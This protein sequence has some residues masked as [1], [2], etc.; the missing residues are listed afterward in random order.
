MS[1][2]RQVALLPAG[3]QPWNTD[4]CDASGE[5][6]AYSATLAIYIYQLDRKFNEFKLHSVMSEHKKTITAISWNPRNPDI[7]ASTGADNQV[8]VWNIPQQR[9]LDKITTKT[10]PN[11]VGW[12]LHE[13]DC[14]SFVCGRGPLCMWNYGT[15]GG[16]TFH[17][18]AQNF[19]SDICQ[20]RWHHKKLGKLAFGHT[21]GSLS[22][23]NP[24]QKSQKHVL[25][26]ETLEGTD[27][28]DPVSDLDWD[29][30]SSEYLL[31]SNTH[32]GVRLIDTDS[33]SIIMCFQL[34]SAAAQVHSIAWI[35]SAP[36]M[37]LTG[38]SH[39]GVM[40]M[41]N[42]SKASPIENIKLK[43]MGFHA[44]HVFSTAPQPGNNNN[45]MATSQGVS[46]TSYT[47]AP[48]MSQTN[49]FALPPAHAV[50]TF[51]DGGVGLYDLG[52]RKWNFLRSEGHVETIFD[53][54]FKPD[55]PDLLAT[56]SFDGTVKVWDITDMTAVETS[57]GN[58][59]V[60]YSIT[61]APGD[62]NCIAGSTSRQGAFIWDIDKGKIVKRFTEHGKHSV[63]SVA[64]CPK[65]S[66][67]IATCG[68]DGHCI[69]RQVDGKI[70]QK[71]KHPAAVFGCDWS[72]HNKDMIATGCEDK[73]VRV[74]YLPTN[75]EQPLKIFAGHSAK[76][77]HVRWSPLREGI[78]CSGSDD[79]GI[80]IW[81]YTQDACINFLEGHKAPVR[82]LLW[83]SEIP[84]LLISG[85]WDYTIRIWDIRDGACIDTVLDHG[86]DVYGLACHPSRPFILASCSRDSTLR[87][88]SLT[89]LV[90]PLQM[91]ILAKR[92]WSE[93]I[94]TAENATSGVSPLLTGKVSKD[95]RAQLEKLQEPELYCKT[96]KLFSNFFTHPGG[97]QNLWELVGVINGKADCYLSSNYSKGIMHSKHLTKY[98]ASA[99]QELEMVK[100]SRSSG[101]G[102]PKKEDQLR[103]AA[104]MHIRLGNIQRYCELMV[105]LGEWERAMAVA[106][107]VS[108]D[109]WKSLADRHAD[110]LM[111]QENELA[112]PFCIATGSAKKC[113]DFLTSQGHLQEAMLVAEATIE[114]SINP[115]SKPSKKPPLNCNGGETPNEDDLSM[116]H[117]T[118]DTL[119]DW[120]FRNGSPI[121][122]ACCHLS[123]DHCQKA[124][125]K[126]IRG[127]EL[128][129]AVS[130]GR[131]LKNQDVGALTNVATE[132][133]VR[134]CENIGKWELA[135][136]LLKDT[137]DSERHLVR[138]CASCAASQ[139]EIDDL[140]SKAGLPSMQKCLK[141][142]E[143][144]LS[145][146]SPEDCVKYY[147]LSTQPEK[148]LDVGLEHIKGQMQRSVWKVADVYPVLQLLGYI[149]TEKLQQQKCAKYCGE[150]LALSAY[151]GALVAIGRGYDTIV[152]PLFEHTRYLL[153]SRQPNIPLSE[154]QLDLDL[155]AWRS[156]G[157]QD[158]DTLGT[159][160]GSAC[161]HYKV[162]RERIGVEPYPVERG[163]DVAA[164]SAMPSHSDV[165]MSVLNGRR[166]QGLAFFLEDG[167]S[168]VSISDA[169]M[170]SK[171]NP[172]SPLAT[173]AR[174]NP[175]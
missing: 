24:G 153:K 10:T 30:L 136:D 168:A 60:I 88:W 37:F 155:A 122:A 146:S 94:G 150:L 89:P 13:R 85:S 164:G 63:Y 98:K 120:Y 84:Y 126:L 20:F 169:I 138:L 69:I 90:E 51:L 117:N 46:S 123:V 92:P 113:V 140:H 58:E 143:T 125:S 158:R 109:Y 102:A 18:E 68:A 48:T 165:H 12:C 104:N 172:F 131:V 32:F 132:Y 142:A 14:V 106:P 163:V 56:A 11:S 124:M 35:P 3:C 38:D 100:M 6:F 118:A 167:R 115:P 139:S 55:N 133:L 161:E 65:D 151:V 72:P 130:I 145:Q 23:F 101:I 74:Y 9:A 25:R 40:R 95:L 137:D 129:L 107:G 147:I 108:L 34:P 99:A 91:N 31:V 47:I 116:L 160:Y 36:G 93:I 67:R 82:G 4:V 28:E 81:D 50:C 170:W 166:I 97:S 33:L 128:E 112:I 22:L 173:G 156:Q 5:R 27:E 76:V 73:T 78:L 61:W 127:N 103:E 144:L 71:Y 59:G 26:P 157:E 121:L 7:L 119:A 79:G 80:R 159:T 17:K 39:V 66:R 114:G 62:I 105:D 43:K 162:L 70:L 86:A 16:L 141:K 175:F 41:W 52:K 8:I 49:R 42:V 57:P 154:Q 44:L 77:F 110:F 15:G 45:K 87:I 54:K 148:A 75:S 19:L 64:W 111:E 134:R 53:C 29:P 21:D 174:I 96:L 171:V 149:M 83:S 152:V 2:V 135:V 1:K